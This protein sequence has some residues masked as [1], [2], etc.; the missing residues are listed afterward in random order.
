MTTTLFGAE[1]SEKVNEQLQSLAEGYARLNQLALDAPLGLVSAA[2]AHHAR[3]SSFG[4]STERTLRIADD[5]DKEKHRQVMWENREIKRSLDSRFVKLSS[6]KVPRY[7]RETRE[8]LPGAKFSDSRRPVFER[9]KPV[10]NTNGFIALKRYRG[11]YHFT[12]VETQREEEPPGP[13]NEKTKST[14][15]RRKSTKRSVAAKGDHSEIIAVAKESMREAAASVK[16]AVSVVFFF[17][18]V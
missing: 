1:N 9:K 2:A 14:S 18:S 8:Q 4:L 16:R 11:G 10:A 17:L 13:E 6:K 7:R 3:L 15:I 5:W 12:R